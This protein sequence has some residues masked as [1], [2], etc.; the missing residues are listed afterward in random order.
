MCVVAT[1]LRRRVA[2]AS[3]REGASIHL[4]RTGDYNEIA[5]VVATALCRRVAEAPAT[6]GKL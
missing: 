6:A 3:S 2:E 4:R 5:V 1:A